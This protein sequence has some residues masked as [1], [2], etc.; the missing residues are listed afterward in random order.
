[1]TCDD[2]VSEEISQGTTRFYGH[3]IH[4]A[5]AGEIRRSAEAET[6]LRR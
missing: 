3:E 4:A 5:G 1:L 2:P 6:G